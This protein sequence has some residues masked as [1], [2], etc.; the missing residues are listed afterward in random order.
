MVCVVEYGKDIGTL[1]NIF[2]D[3]DQA[4]F[5]VKRIIELGEDE[6]TCIAAN[7]WYCRNK[8]EYLEIKGL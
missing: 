8:N 1:K 4:I 2:L 6:Y 7:K 5:F 3:V